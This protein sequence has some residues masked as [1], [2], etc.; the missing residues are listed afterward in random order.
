VHTDTGKVDRDSSLMSLARQVLEPQKDRPDAVRDVP[1]AFQRPSYYTLQSGTRQVPVVVDLSE[2]LRLCLD[3][4]GSGM[5]AQEPCLA[6]KAWEP[7]RTVAGSSGPS[8]C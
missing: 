1:A 5:L 4:R 7:R 3:T 6:A 8:Q 2:K